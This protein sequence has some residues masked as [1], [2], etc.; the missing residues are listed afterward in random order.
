MAKD[1]F[2]DKVLA[3]TVVG[4][5]PVV[6]GGGLLS[7]LDPLRPSVEIAVADQIAA[8]IDII[9]DGQVRG[10]MIRAFTAKLPGIRGQEVIGKVQPA[11]APITVRDT[12]YALS[13]A[14]SVKGIITG[15]TTLAHGL[16]ISTPMY[17]N[18]GELALDLAAALVVEATSLQAAGVTLLQIDEPIFSTGIADLS[19]G[20]QAIEMITNTLHVPTCM[21]VCGDLS[22]VIDDLL[23]IQVSVLDFEFSKNPANIA[24][25]SSRELSGRMVGFG[26]V[27]STTDAVDS[28]PEIKERIGKGI[29]AFGARALLLDPDCGMRMLTRD[30]AFAKLKNLVGAA[31]EV[32]LAL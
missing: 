19:V 24:L 6:R 14:R 2:I 5:Y 9:S 13:K 25:V 30:A 28:V 10:D 31:K 20:K 17:R 27:D 3:T 4:S 15:P 26:C 32:R 8:G 11:S 22:E 18:K 21:H 7:L 23:K 29:E 16:H 12:K 1:Y